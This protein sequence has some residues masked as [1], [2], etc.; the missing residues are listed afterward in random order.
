[1]DI[2]DHEANLIAVSVQQDDR[3]IPGIFVPVK[4]QVPDTVFLDPGKLFAIFT[5]N[6]QHVVLKSRNAVCVGKLFNHF[7]RCLF[8]HRI[9]LPF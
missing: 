6:Q 2:V 1:M 8:F 9:S 7:K 3:L 4:K 5:A